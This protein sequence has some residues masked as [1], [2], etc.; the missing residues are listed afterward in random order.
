MKA[1]RDVLFGGAGSGSWFGDIGLL[2]LRLTGLILAVGHGLKKWPP[3][4]MFVGGVQKLGFPA[5]T[6]FAWMAVLSEVVGGFLLAL[7]L[8]TRP[9]AFLVAGTML[10]AAFGQHRSDPFFMGPTGP[11]KEPAIL[12]L[13]PAL[14]LLFTGAGRYGVDY[15]LRGR[16]NES[17]GF[18]VQNLDNAAPR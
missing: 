17:T 7:G 13:L 11:S 16:R 3:P 14:A 10:V 5:P 9:A 12:F 2:V 6:F 18:P 4:E 15:F 8:L 1:L